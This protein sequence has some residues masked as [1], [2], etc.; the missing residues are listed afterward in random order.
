MTGR[1]ANGQTGK[2]VRNG[3]A[4]DEAEVQ[5]AAS[6]LPEGEGRVP[7]KLSIKI[8]AEQRASG[9]QHATASWN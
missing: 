1:P 7:S 6:R 4:L 9:A 2:C 8:S 3:V 5:E